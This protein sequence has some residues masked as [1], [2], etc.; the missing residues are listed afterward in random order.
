MV[1]TAD[2]KLSGP[3]SGS[4]TSLANVKREIEDTR[5]RLT[6]G[7][8]RTT[9]RLRAL[10]TDPA[11]GAHLPQEAGALGITVRSLQ[12]FQ[13]GRG[14]WAR[15]RAAGTVRRVSA[16][17]AAVGIAAMVAVRT[18]RRRLATLSRHAGGATGEEIVLDGG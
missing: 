18:R 4:D 5:L 12:A 9:E 1:E 3:S 2:R 13:R 14:L 11:V 6:G 7:I 8:A 16:A 10:L 17:A 15:A